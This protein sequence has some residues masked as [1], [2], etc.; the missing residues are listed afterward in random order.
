MVE[1]G[2]NCVAQSVYHIREWSEVICCWL[3]SCTNNTSTDMQVC[4]WMAHVR[5]VEHS[6]MGVRHVGTAIPP[7]LEPSPR[8]R[9]DPIVISILAGYNGKWHSSSIVIRFVLAH[10]YV[11]SIYMAMNRYAIGPSLIHCSINIHKP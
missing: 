10:S 11:H 3:C 1:S 8:Q 4:M 6:C 9:P 7:W 5:G 2:Q